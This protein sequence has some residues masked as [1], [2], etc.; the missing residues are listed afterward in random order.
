MRYLYLILFISS[1]S[2]SQS[3][4]TPGMVTPKVKLDA[5]SEKNYAIYLPK[6]YDDSKKY[7]VVFVF[8]EKGRGDIITQ[9]FTIGAALTNSIVIG[10]NY[11]LNDSLS[12]AL[13]ESEVLINK[14]YDLYAVDR[15]K[16]ILAGFGDGGLVASASAQLANTVYG[17][18]AVGD[19][20]LDKKLLQ[21]NPRLKVSIL[22]PDEGKNFY[23]LRGYG[24]SYIIDDFI[25]G[26][27]EY[28]G[29][30]LPESGYLAAA[31]TELLLDENT[32][33]AEIQAYYESDM[34]FGDLLYR[35]RQHL[36]AYDFVSNLKQKYRKRIDI[37]SQ[38]ELLKELRLN[39]SFRA[40]R[41]R[42]TVIT[43]KEGLLA[44]DFQY[45]M[46]E[47]TEKAFFDNLGWWSYQMD[48]L[49]AKIDSTAGSQEERKSAIRLKG[50]VQ[51]SL[52][53][54]YLILKEMDESPEQLLF[55]NVL[56]TLV[57]PTNQDAFLQVIGLSAR[58]G[59]TNAALFYLEELLKSGYTDYE[60]L[61]ELPYTTAL[62]I[63]PDWN[64]IVKAY[65]GKS[66][67]Y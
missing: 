15:D 56:R 28:N 43:Y 30:V 14:A 21:R 49:D 6:D 10:A 34:A 63:G 38:K 67:Y 19:A 58:E 39:R 55:V 45:Y 11:K 25:K 41:D 60:Q 27:H 8:D 2:F 66:K 22:S 61:Y 7:P 1:V 24:S 16:I 53:Q 51:T 12:I 18:I 52:E 17:L 59:D 54:R 20:F 35:K 46:A 37:D 32:P 36:Y 50:Y 4:L 5:V 40:K 33:E 3:G 31:L 62:R 29:G 23:K 57:D 44:E 48:E 65:L 64:E 26:Y 47:D 9:Q 13:K 42:N